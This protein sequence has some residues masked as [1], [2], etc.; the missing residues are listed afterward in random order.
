MATRGID[1]HAHL[2][3]ETFAA[4]I[5]AVTYRAQATC[6]AVLLPNLDETTLP[7]VQNLIQKAPTFYYGMIGLHPTHVRADFHQQIQILQSALSDPRWIAIGEVGLDAYHD[8]DSLPQ[9]REA[10]FIQAQWAKELDLPLSIHFRSALEETLEV[11]RPFFGEI[12]GVFHCFT[13]SWEEARRILDAGFVLGLGGVV[14]FRNAVTLHEAVRR[15]PLGSF[16]LETDSP[17]LAP[18]PYRGRRNESS[19]LPL[20]AKAIAELRGS[21]IEAIWEE[22]TA[23]AC[24]IFRLNL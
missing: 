7:A 16:V 2:F 6:K 8:A 4:D 10:L 24:Q 14:T 5:E 11:L 18:H 13:G 12:R 1:T 9:Q 19:Y 22:T 3:L 17:Y 15:L 20:I 21:P 23:T